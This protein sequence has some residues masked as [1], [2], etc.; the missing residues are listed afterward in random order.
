MTLLQ[1]A[2][3]INGHKLAVGSRTRILCPSWTPAHHVSVATAPLTHSLTSKSK[4]MSKGVSKGKSKEKKA[5][6]SSLAWIDS[7]TKKY[8]TTLTHSHALSELQRASSSAIFGSEDSRCLLLVEAIDI[9]ECGDWMLKAEDLSRYKVSY[10]VKESSECVSECVSKDEEVF[11]HSNRLHLSS[12]LIGSAAA[13]TECCIEPAVFP[14]EW[15]EA[16]DK[17]CKDVKECP[18]VVICGAKGVGKSTSLRYTLNRLM[19][20]T[21]CV[22]LL[23][24]DLGQSEFTVSGLVSLHILSTPLLSPSHL[25]LRKPELSFFIGDTTLKADPGLFEVALVRLYE[26]YLELR[27][28]YATTGDVASLS[29]YTPCDVMDRSVSSTT[30]KDTSDKR[31]SGFSA[32][33][34]SPYSKFA[35]PLV[36]NTDGWIRSM[37]LEVLTSIITT[38]KPTHVIH[39]C[40][41][42]NKD[43]PA[44]YQLG[45]V[46]APMVRAKNVSVSEDQT[47]STTTSPSANTGNP[48]SECSSGNLTAKIFTLK[49][50]R[51]TAS[52]IAA[53]DLRNLR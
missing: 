3:C 1:G 20:K 50:V 12:L 35:L 31:V 32:L 10:N 15:V 47:A 13:M 26:R 34:D 49:P 4:S 7:F 9:D 42:K 39:L 22:A 23:D 18:R 48:V 27:D 2:V 40:T 46:P 45:V 29:T 19:S 37:G 11:I 28:V 51:N 38:T 24:C 33:D 44:L 16:V 53:V 5:L 41:D 43:L 30:G 14:L 8:T 36:V 17:V 25:R 21:K 6:Q 52:K